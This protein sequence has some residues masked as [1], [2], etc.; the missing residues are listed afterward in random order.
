MKKTPADLMHEATRL[1][2]AGDAAGA[3]A[4]FQE[5]L[6]GQQP[7]KTETETVVPAADT[8]HFVQDST[9]A[10]EM[11]ASS[12]TDGVHSHL[13]T[14]LNYKLFIPTRLNNEPAPL[15]LMLHGCSQNAQDFATSTRMNDIAQVSGMYVLYPA[16]SSSANPNKC[17][18]WFEPAHQLRGSGEPEALSALTQHIMENQPID[19][20][21]VFVAGF[22]AG[23]AMALIMA[24]QYPEL[25]TAAGVHSGLPTGAASSNMEAFRVMQGASTDNTNSTEHPDMATVNPSDQD[26][27]T[28]SDQPAQ[29]RK[30]GDIHTPL[31]VFQG[32]QDRFV[33][34][35]NADRI[36]ANWLAREKTRTVPIYWMPLSLTHNTA[37]GHHCIVTTYAAEEQPERTGCEYWLLTEGGHGW[38]GGNS[39][40]SHTEQKGPDASAEMVRFFLE[41]E[42]A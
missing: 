37:T 24:E 31:I 26:S 7:E 41:C 10:A 12:F 23:G 22:S 40:S 18:N 21:R 25:Y 42:S 8:E 34:A 32:S 17:W 27:S 14:E 19:S 5:V 15:L 33:N 2:L 1:T 6:A 11:P 13:G 16:Q 4:L 3:A 39:S 20:Q 38:S 30:T 28:D 36:V 29:I 9:M 35:A